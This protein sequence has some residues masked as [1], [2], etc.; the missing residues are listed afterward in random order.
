[1]GAES[2]AHGVP[3]SVDQLVMES[4]IFGSRFPLMSNVKFLL[5]RLLN[6]DNVLHFHYR[7]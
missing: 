1:M 2:Q 7:N 3:P 6:I 5:R 4:V